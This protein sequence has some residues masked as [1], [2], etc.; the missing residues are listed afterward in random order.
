MDE[1]ES[2]ED[3]SDFEIIQKEDEDENDADF[4][5]TRE[6]ANREYRLLFPVSFVTTPEI[7]FKKLLDE[8]EPIKNTDGQIRIAKIIEN[9]HG[10]KIEYILDKEKEI[11]EDNQNSEKYKE[12][13][14]QI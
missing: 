14:S 13:N 8:S 5:A 3:V 12:R 4:I 10:P 6:K 2:D 11:M 9:G 7:M 1:I